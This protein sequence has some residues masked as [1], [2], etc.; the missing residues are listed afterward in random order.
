MSRSSYNIQD[1]LK[2]LQY[3]ASLTADGD[4]KCMAHARAAIGGGAKKQVLDFGCGDGSVTSSRFEDKNLYD[5][6]GVDRDSFAIEYATAH[7]ARP[8]IIYKN[9]ELDEFES[10]SSFDIVFASYVLH[11]NTQALEL[12]Q[13]LWR[14]T[15]SPGALIVRTCNDNLLRQDGNNEYARNLSAHAGRSPGVSQRFHGEQMA[16]HA[17]SLSPPPCDVRII[18]TSLDSSVMTP[19]GRRDFFDFVCQRQ[20]GYVRNASQH[21]EQMLDLFRALSAKY[22]DERERFAAGNAARWTHTLQAWTLIKA[23]ASQHSLE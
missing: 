5:V 9:A 1:D 4:L 20:L 13:R 12:L 21:N 10:E 8:N 17:A 23:D 16:T 11:H 18:S 2:V 15:R 22:A 7:N 19:D 14:L 3:Q 6:T